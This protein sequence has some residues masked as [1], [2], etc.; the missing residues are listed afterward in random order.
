MPNI[1][2]AKK[3]MRQNTKRRTAN[4]M[5]KA[6]IRTY[7]KKIRG[8]VE[9]KEVDKANEAY[10]TFSSLIDRAAKSNI[11]HKNTA[12]RKKSRLNQLIQRSSA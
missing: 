10:K 4:R 3:R 5:K 8:F 9:T 11:V 12:G 1:Q 2:S 7:E 6:A